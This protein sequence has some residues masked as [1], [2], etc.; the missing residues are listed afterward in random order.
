MTPE[1][2]KRLEDAGWKVGTVAEMLELSPEDEAVIEVK[3][4]I[5]TELNAEGLPSGYE[6][7]CKEWEARANHSE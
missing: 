5:A 4:Q 6:D 1:K 3:V 7:A 2:R